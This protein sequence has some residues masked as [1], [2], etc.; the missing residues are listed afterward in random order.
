MPHGKMKLTKCLPHVLWLGH[1]HLGAIRWSAED[2][3]DLGAIQSSIFF[4]SF[5]Y[6]MPFI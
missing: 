3:F 4:Y 5:S 6:V 2:K 1:F